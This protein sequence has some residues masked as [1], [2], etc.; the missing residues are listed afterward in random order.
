[1][2]PAFTVVAI[3]AAYNEADI[4]EQ[5]VGD[6][7]AQGIQ[8][9][10]LDDGSTDG[11]AEKVERFVGRGVLQ[12]ERTG[13]AGRFEWERILHRKTGLA[14]AIDADWFIHH[15]ADEFR[16]SPWTGVPLQEAIQRVDARG[17]NAIDFE[18]FD[19]WPTHDRFT[20]G[21]DVRRAFPCFSRRANYDRVQIRCW[22]KT[23][24]L[25]LA[26]SGGH[27]ARFPDRRVFPLRFILRHYPIRGQ[28]HGERKVFDERRRRYVDAERARGWHVQYESVPLGVSFI[29]DEST[30][31]RYDPDAVRLDLLLRHRGVEEAEDA[32]AE[33]RLESERVHGALDAAAAELALQSAELDRLRRLLLTQNA[34]LS[35]RIVELTDKAADIQRLEITVADLSA[36]LDA[37]ERS[38]SWRT[39]APAR[40]AFRLI[41][42]ADS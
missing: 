24:G 31:A 17:Y 37:F 35:Q 5:V 2:S 14:R 3:I 16:E 19:F 15:D 1:M 34:E 33:A 27:D 7:I 21:E 28:A 6:L 39:T 42:G 29:R 13:D 36:R 12:I 8:V 40:W 11:T 23:S 20:S 41:T 38:L 18:S 25:D 4:I 10:F 32:T 9:Y 26:S 30:L 22:K